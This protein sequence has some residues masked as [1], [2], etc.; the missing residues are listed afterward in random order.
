MR[1]SWRQERLAPVPLDIVPSATPK[2]PAHLRAATRRWF[3]QVLR[4]WRL[5]AH[6]VRLLTLA[7]VAWDRA[8]AARE[9]IDA[10]GLLVRSARGGPR[11]HPALRVEDASRRAFQ[12][13]VAQLNLSSAPSHSA[14][15]RSRA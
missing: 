6:H 14:P 11:V 13:L 12:R 4:E 8:E 2:A 9:L 3:R 5:E 10:D 1:G 7:C 15:P